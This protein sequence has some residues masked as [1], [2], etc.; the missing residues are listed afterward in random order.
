[1]P[2]FHRRQVERVFVY[3]FAITVNHHIDMIHLISVRYSTPVI[4]F[5]VEALANRV[6][7]A[8]AL[9]DSPDIGFHPD[10]ASDH[11]SLFRRLPA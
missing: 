8:D 4:I 2:A 1:V 9:L 5:S 6:S 11:E 3:R 7:S 10:N